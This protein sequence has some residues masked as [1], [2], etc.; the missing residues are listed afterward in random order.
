M[1]ENPPIKPVGELKPFNPTKTSDIKPVGQLKPF[2]PTKQ[3]RKDPYVEMLNNQ[4]SQDDTFNIID[5]LPEMPGD[6]DSKKEILKDLVRNGGTADEV[7]S[8]ILTLQGKHPHQEGGT[9]YYTN[10]KGVAIPLKNNEKPPAGYH[11]ASIFG[12]PK[13]AKDDN[14]ITDLAKTAW[15]ILPSVGENAVALAQTVYQGVTN[16][17]SD[18]LNSLKN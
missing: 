10:D 15:N 4:S 16:E 13:D 9:K 7:N 14:F 8:S 11:I 17:S 3:P 6:T 1:P 2:T 5:S 18:N 12:S